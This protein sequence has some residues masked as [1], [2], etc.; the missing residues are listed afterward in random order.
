MTMMF[1]PLAESVCLQGQL[2]GKTGGDQN[3]CLF[4]T[5]PAAI[6]ISGLLSALY[7]AVLFYIRYLFVHQ[8]FD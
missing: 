7:S 4:A 8:N 3:N 6:C 5:D 1:S 2:V